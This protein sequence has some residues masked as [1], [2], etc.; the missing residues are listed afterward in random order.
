M[1]RETLMYRTECS[2]WNG[3][4]I[5]KKITAAAFSIAFFLCTASCSSLS[6]DGGSYTLTQEISAAKLTNHMSD[7]ERNRITVGE[8]TV[9]EHEQNN[10]IV[11]ADGVYLELWDGE[12][13]KDYY[14]HFNE[15]YPDYPLTDEE[16]AESLES[17]V[18]IRD[19]IKYAFVDGDVVVQTLHLLDKDYD[20]RKITVYELE[21]VMMCTDE[22]GNMGYTDRD[23]NRLTQEE[24][25]DILEKF[26]END[27]QIEF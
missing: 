9:F 2:E 13:Y 23:G 11:P 17:T 22:Q 15:N 20:G 18:D 21:P 14:E 25:E 5:M 4:M 27:P 10:A 8:L 6:G 1:L 3:G 24:A 16:I 7:N 19:E 26:Y 12:D